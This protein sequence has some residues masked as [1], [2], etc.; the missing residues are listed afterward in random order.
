MFG[1]VVAG[2]AGERISPTVSCN[3]SSID[4]LE[5]MIHKFW[6]VKSFEKGKAFSLEEQYCENHFR[7]THYRASDG[8]FVVRLPIRGGMLDSLGESFKISEHRFSS[9][10]RKLSSEPQLHLQY[11]DFL[12]EYSSLGHMEEIKPNIPSST[13]H[14]FSSASCD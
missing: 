10:E 1:Y 8:R 13:S 2:E 12:N 9:I 4:K 14:F 11:S 5:S 3:V 7:K 6:E